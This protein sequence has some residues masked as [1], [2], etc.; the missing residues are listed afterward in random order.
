MKSKNIEVFKILPFTVLIQYDSPNFIT[1][2]DNFNQFYTNIK[3]HL[4]DQANAEKL[5]KDHSYSLSSNKENKLKKYSS[6]F[7]IPGVGN[8]KIGAKSNVFIDPNLYDNKNFWVVKASDLNRGRCI[9]IADSLSQIQKLVKRFYEGIY[10]DFAEDNDDIEY[11][12]FKSKNNLSDEE[13]KNIMKK[14]YRSSFVIIQKYIE[15]PLLYRGRKFDMRI[16]VLITHKMNVYIFK[17]GHLKTSSVEFDINVKNSYVHITNYS[18]QKYNEQFSK[19]E[20]GNEVSFKD[21]QVIINEIFN[22]NYN[23]KI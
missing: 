23:R 6:L 8:E 18:I 3:D 11:E 15:K 13:K 5:K 12:P 9:K 14:K 21:F 17:E 22:N 2:M 7:S 4:L 10:K 16:W 20:F 1:Q 19:H